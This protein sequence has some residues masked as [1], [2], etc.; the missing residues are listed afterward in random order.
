MMYFDECAN[1]IGVVINIAISIGKVE[2][3][4]TFPDFLDGDVFA[5]GV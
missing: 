5:K 4:F 3:V 1:T 2:T